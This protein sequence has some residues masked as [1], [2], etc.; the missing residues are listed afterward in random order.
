MTRS[1]GV[2]VV[3]A[4][5]IFVAARGKKIEPIKQIDAPTITKRG[6]GRIRAPRRGRR[7]GPAAARLWRPGAA[8]FGRRAPGRAPPAT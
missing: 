3:C 4:K 1:C 2:G 6:K 7:I 8:G 5:A